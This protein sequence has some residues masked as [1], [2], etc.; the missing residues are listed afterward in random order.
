MRKQNLKYLLM[1]VFVHVSGTLF[2]QIDPCV[3]YIRDANEKYQEGWYDEAIVK[4]K[5]SLSDCPLTKTE[6]IEAYKLLTLNY[7]AIDK[8]EEAEASV[9]AI[10]K[11]NP[12]YEADKL[13][14]PAEVIAL[15]Q[16]YKPIPYLKVLVMGGLNV[17]SVQANKLHSVTQHQNLNDL[18]NYTRT[19]RFQFGVALEYKT[20]K[21]FWLQTGLLYR[22]VSYTN[23]LLNVQE[24]TISYTEDIGYFDIPFVVKHYFLQDRF[25]PFAQAGLNL[26]FLNSA[27]GEL[28]RD[29][30]SDIVDRKSQR[31]SLYTGYSVGVGAS[32][33]VKDFSFQA[34]VTYLKTP[35]NFNKAGTRYDNLDLVFKYYYLD[36]DFAMDNLQFN[37][38]I[39][40]NLGY[41]NVISKR[42]EGDE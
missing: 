7:I 23:Q 17:T 30:I 39:S 40:Y 5:K 36:N 38:G 32:Y 1:F 21:S 31:K 35:A 42:G 29:N 34:A 28:S 16:K 20:Y 24:R 9:A 15:Y 25:R 10:M 8:I 27:L 11:I 12:N 13:D 41:K 33:K 3:T 4:V 6:K 37:L 14:D 2:S 26:S 18:D 22:A 19:P